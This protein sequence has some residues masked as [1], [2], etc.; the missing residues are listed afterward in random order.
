MVAVY[1][2]L[3]ILVQTY[4]SMQIFFPHIIQD[5]LASG[6]YFQSSLTPKNES[7]KQ[8]Q[9]PETLTTQKVNIRKLVIDSSYLF[10]CLFTIFY[11]LYLT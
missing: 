1:Y 2:K 10:S 3:I 7:M 11:N 9:S 8:F 4:L 5:T 6:S